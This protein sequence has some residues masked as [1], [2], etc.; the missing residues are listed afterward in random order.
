MSQN[1]VDINMKV[2]SDG[3]ADLE[4][5]VNVAEPYYFIRPKSSLKQFVDLTN[6]DVAAGQVSYKIVAVAYKCAD[7]ATRGESRAVVRQFSA[8]SAGEIEIV[9]PP[10]GRR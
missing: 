3:P 8:V 4:R 10:V 6:F 9:N 5:G 2:I 1:G 7:I